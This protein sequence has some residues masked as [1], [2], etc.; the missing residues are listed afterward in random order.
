MF[1]TFFMCC[2]FD[3]AWTPALS[4]TYNNC[5]VS[6]IAMPPGSLSFLT[7]IWWMNL[8]RRS[9]TQIRFLWLT[10]SITVPSLPNKKKQR[11]RITLI[12]IVSKLRREN[13]IYSRSELTCPNRMPRNGGGLMDGLTIAK[14]SCYTCGAKKK[15]SATSGNR[16]GKKIHNR[17][18]SFLARKEKMV[19]RAAV[20][21]NNSLLSFVSPLVDGVAIRIDS[22]FGSSCP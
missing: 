16:I 21:K 3:L 20:G 6:S 14:G 1:L 11:E 9:N 12:W 4:N 8:P 5:L 22:L 13:V 18:E 7:P 19:A 15:E 2:R 17:S 10:S